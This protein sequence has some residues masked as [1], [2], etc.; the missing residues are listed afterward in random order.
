MND[1]QLKEYEERLEEFRKLCD[2]HKDRDDDYWLLAWAVH[3]LANRYLAAKLERELVE[4][5]KTHE[6]TKR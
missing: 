6:E 3:E 2:S 5:K 4:R 1:E